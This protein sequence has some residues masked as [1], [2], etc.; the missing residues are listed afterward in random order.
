MSTLPGGALDPCNVSHRD[1]SLKEPRCICLLAAQ[2][3]LGADPAM[4]PLFTLT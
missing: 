4:C 1:F 3:E 2:A